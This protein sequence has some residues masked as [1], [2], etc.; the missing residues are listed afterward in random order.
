M[1]Y[2]RVRE[3][4]IVTLSSWKK[5]WQY[6]IKDLIF[7]KGAYK[8]EQCT[9]KQAYKCIKQ[10]DLDFSAEMTSNWVAIIIFFHN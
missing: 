1:G 8:Y 7:K 3:G 10:I 5:N 4:M 6:N 2:D 9:Q